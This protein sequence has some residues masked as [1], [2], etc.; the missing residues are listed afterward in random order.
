M[1]FTNHDHF[2]HSLIKTRHLLSTSRYNAS[3]LLEACIDTT[4]FKE[5]P[6]NSESEFFYKNI[7]LEINSFDFFCEKENYLILEPEKVER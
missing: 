3:S 7:F 1:K 2:I 5:V 4:I 6:Q